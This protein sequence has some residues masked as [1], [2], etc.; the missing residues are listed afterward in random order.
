[1][2]VS[3]YLGKI[4]YSGVPQGFS[5]SYYLTG[6]TLSAAKTALSNLVT[7]RK[8]MISNTLDIEYANVSQLGVKR[9]SF[10]V[11]NGPQAGSDTV[12]ANVPN[13]LSD[14]LLIRQESQ[15]GRI[16]NRYLHGVPDPAVINGSYLVGG[17]AAFDTALAA[18][19]TA[20]Q[21]NSGFLKKVNPADQSTWIVE[22][23][24]TITNRGLT[25]HKVGRPFDLQRG[26]RPT[27]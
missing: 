21:T 11:I 22:T 17:V 6:S 14:A 13:R 1:M 3:I 8:G 12:T 7:A 24:G 16:C 19:L 10:I 25:S 5:E 2:S 9:D 18:Y 20:L 4:Q 15:A 23:W 27:A 26:R